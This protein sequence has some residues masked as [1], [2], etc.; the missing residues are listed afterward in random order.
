[1]PA[2]RETGSEKSEREGVQMERGKRKTRQ[3]E[4]M[5][6]RGSSKRLHAQRHKV[7]TIL[8]CDFIMMGYN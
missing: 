7:N 5:R 1:M 4:D 2:E 6:R 3:D 8:T